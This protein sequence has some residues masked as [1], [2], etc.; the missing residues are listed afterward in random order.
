MQPISLTRLSFSPQPTASQRDLVLQALQG[1]GDPEQLT[2]AEAVELKR[3]CARWFGLDAATAPLLRAR[4][5]K[6]AVVFSV[7]G[8]G[9]EHAIIVHEGRADEDPLLLYRVH[10]GHRLV[11]AMHSTLRYLKHVVDLAVDECYA[12]SQPTDAL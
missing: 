10:R 6:D 9:P 1:W 5:W 3:L 11:P 2:D 8:V 7:G 4:M 12:A